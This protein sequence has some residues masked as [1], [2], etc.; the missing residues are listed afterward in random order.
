M[1]KTRHSGLY[2]EMEERLNNLELQLGCFFVVS[3]LL[4][5]TF[6]HARTVLS[7]IYFELLNARFLRIFRPIP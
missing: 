5:Q 2:R 3:A 1:S 7:S 4:R 6:V